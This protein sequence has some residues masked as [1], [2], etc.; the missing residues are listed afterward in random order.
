MNRQF[1]A[2]AAFLVL[3]ITMMACALP[4]ELGGGPSKDALETVVALTMQ[5]LTPSSNGEATP[6]NERSLMGA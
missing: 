5:A 6:T 4:F 2:L 3:A 1:R